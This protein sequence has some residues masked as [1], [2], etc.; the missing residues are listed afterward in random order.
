MSEQSQDIFDV[1]RKG[2]L[3]QLKRLYETDNSVI[4]AEDFKGFTPLIIAVYNN[5]IDV[6]DFLLEK[7]ARVDVQDGSG[8]T[9]LMGVSF[10]GYE[11]LAAK[12]IEAGADVNQRNSNG[13]TA[14]TFA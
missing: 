12:L 6:A 5:N 7:G 2:D 8:N 1:C 14:L 9:A 10:R 11:E 4:Q 13:A 3:K